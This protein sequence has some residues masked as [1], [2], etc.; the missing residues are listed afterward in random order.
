MSLSAHRV[1]GLTAEEVPPDWPPLTCEELQPLLAQFAQ[2]GQ[3]D[4]IRWHSPRPL[5]AAALVATRSGPVF[6]KRHSGLVRSAV[7]L[8]EE[9]AFAQWLRTHGIPIPEILCNAHGESA[10]ALNGWT[11]EVH[12]LAEGI[13]LHRDTMS[14]VPL[15]NLAHARSAGRMLARLHLA[16]EGYRAA[17]RSTHLLVARSELLEAEDPIATLQA[18]LPQRPALA[19]YLA[20]RH[21]QE[22]LQRTLQPHSAAMRHA[23]ATQPRLWTHGDWHA[24]NLFWSSASEHANITGVLDFSL[25]AR[26]F[27]LFD[28]AT[29]IERS[30]IAWLQPDDQ[31]AQP[32]IANALIDGYREICPLHRSERELLVALLPVVHLD[33]ALSEVEY[34]CGVLHA[35]AHADVAWDTFLHGHAA[36]FSTAYGQAFLRA[37]EKN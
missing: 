2:L 8:H 25:S 31:R 13:D 37:V 16:A 18:Q 20:Q 10:I 30:A 35:T 15:H 5:S 22:E 27:A 24:S 29:A 33:F 11:Y 21:W 3:L 12:A 4:T 23:F 1:H 17:Q 9:H 32:H 7:T 26:T 6:V 34:F 19:D 28:L 14:W 36:W